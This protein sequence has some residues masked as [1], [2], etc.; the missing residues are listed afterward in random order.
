MKEGFLKERV[1]SCSKNKTLLK[2]KIKVAGE[3]EMKIIFFTELFSSS[4]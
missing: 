3:D 1:V 4:Y 2:R